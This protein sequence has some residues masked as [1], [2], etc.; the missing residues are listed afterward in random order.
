MTSREKKLRLMSKAAKARG[1]SKPSMPRRLAG[2]ISH[3]AQPG[4]DKRAP[5]SGER[6]PTDEDPRFAIRCICGGIA[7]GV[8]PVLDVEG[9]KLIRQRTVSGVRCSGC[10]RTYTVE[11]PYR[12]E[13]SA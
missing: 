4:D 2:T 8:F 6:V 11:W 10:K 13:E 5:A 9:D 3:D 1:R 12:P 7:G